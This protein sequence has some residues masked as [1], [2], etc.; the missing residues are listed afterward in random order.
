MKVAGNIICL[1]GALLWIY[2]FFVAGHAS[3]VDWSFAPWWISELFPNLE[4][5]IGCIMSLVG[6]ILAFVKI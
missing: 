6:S 5:E 2:G 1:V 3:A 4:S